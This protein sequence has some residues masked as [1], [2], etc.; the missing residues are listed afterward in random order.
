MKNKHK[1]TLEN[2]S[3]ESVFISSDHYLIT[4]GQMYV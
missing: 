2:I 1:L 4:L 3:W